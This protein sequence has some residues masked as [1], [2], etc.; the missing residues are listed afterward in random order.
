MQE[1]LV[2]HQKD[3]RTVNRFRVKDN[4][5]IFTIGSGRRSDIRILG[6]DIDVLHA[7]FEKRNGV[8]KILDLGS[9]SGTWVDNSP[10]VELELKHN[11][12][13]NIGSHTLEIQPVELNKYK[14]FRTEKKIDLRG[15]QREVYQQVAIFYK[16]ELI[17]SFLDTPKKKISVPYNKKRYLIDPPKSPE[18]VESK[19][20]DF[21]VKNRLVRSPKFVS[22]DSSLWAIFPEDLVKPTAWAFGI[23]LV[24]F[25]AAFLIPK[26]L[27]KDPGA[28]KENQYT[29][30]IFDEKEI[31]KQKK[32]ALKLTKQIEKKVEKKKPK[33]VKKKQVAKAQAKPKTRG[34][35]LKKVAKLRPSRSNRKVNAKAAK[36]VSKIQKAGLS[37]II[38]KVAKRAGSNSVRIKAR[39]SV[40]ASSRGFAS[41]S[42]LKKGA[43]LASAAKSGS[44]RVGGINTKGVA[45][46]GKVSGALGGLSGAGIGR[47]SVDALEEETEVAGGLSA[48]QIA[49]VVKKNIGAVRYCYERQLAANPNLYGKIKVQFTISGA[50]LV[51][52]QKIKSTTMRSSLV[53]GCILRRVKRWK[54]PKPKGGTEVVVSYPFYFKS[55]Q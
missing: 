28:I 5:E 23:T 49:S 48:E 6:E 25:L 10:I 31:E 38:G 7:C 11:V 1:L 8:W 30:L 52:T 33:A 50:G 14:L 34:P 35:K 4:S 15:E 41:V 24:F 44:F 17:E 46:G 53:E 32:K 29:K 22:S 12:V 19:F 54:F 3:G 2:L 27:R 9:D 42:D 55:T 13:L 45:G 36:V 39:G 40:N 37:S 16:G 51:I 20:G 18:W 21:V 43:K 47:G 26:A